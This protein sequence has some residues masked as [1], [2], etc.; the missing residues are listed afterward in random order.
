MIEVV[1]NLSGV[2]ISIVSGVIGLL[3]VWYLAIKVLKADPGNEQMQTISNLV[4]KGAVAFLTREYKTIF[5]FLFILFFIIFFGIAKKTAFAFLAGAIC[6][7]LAGVIGMNISTLSSS[8]TAKKCEISFNEALGIAFPGGAVMGLSVVSLGLLGLGLVYLIFIIYLLKTGTSLE[9]ALY[10]ATSMIV[11]FSMGASSIALFARVGGG[12]YTKAADVGADLVGKVEKGIPEDDPRNPAVIADNVGDMVGDCAGM[13]ADLYES[14]IG[15][16]VS[17]LV[18][19]VFNLN[20]INSAMLCLFLAVLGIFSS[21]IG[22]FFVRTKTEEDPQKV[23]NKGLIAAV[24]IFVISSFLLIVAW[25]KDINAFWS[26]LSGLIAGMVVGFVAQYYTSSKVVVSLAQQAKTGPATVIIEGTAVGMISTVVP[27]VVI[28]IA[29]IISYK[30]Q[31]VFGIALAAIGML[32]LTGTT[33]AIDAYGPIADNAA[34]IAEMAHMGEEVRR[35]AERLDAV[36][37]TTAAVGKGFAIGSAALTALALFS[38]YAETVGL[39]N[40]GLNILDA[41]VIAGMFVGCI[42]P[43]FL[44]S[45]TLQ[46]VGRAAYSIVEEVRRQFKEIPGLLEGKALPDS[47][48]CVDITTQAALKK[49]ILPGI[50]SVIIPALVGIILGKEALGGFLAGSLVTGVPLA[51]YLANSGGAWDNAKK[52]IEEG[53]LGG[54]GSESHKASVVGDTVGDPFKDTSGPSLNILLKLMSVVALVFGALFI[55]INEYLTALIPFLK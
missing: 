16:I 10:E 43:F 52:Y 4:R 31:G 32:A 41:K 12:I 5:Y 15:A 26:V 55:R 50:S 36:G 25:Y 42:M 24:I 20:N 23:L 9:A 51:I 48:K 8:R 34:G 35:R 38:A 2:I 17:G 30:L 46:A 13:G 14:Y 21:I 40:S 33:V 47:A 1:K 22:V 37:N 53:H 45:K 3:F 27:L 11:G 49:M 28:A 19:S 44:I 18:I 6:S 54:K 7:M 39:G 29:T